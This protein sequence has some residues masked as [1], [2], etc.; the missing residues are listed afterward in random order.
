[1]G[2]NDNRLAR[3][4]AGKRLLNH[5]LVLHV[6]ACRRLV[7]QHDGRI[8]EQRAGDRDALALAAGQ[9]GA[10]LSD[11]SVIAL[12]H[13]VHELVAVGGTRGRKHFLISGITTP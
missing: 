8:F 1:M 11:H 13:A 6:Q 10:V 12:R 7:Q 3:E 2:N 4:Q 5:S 9:L